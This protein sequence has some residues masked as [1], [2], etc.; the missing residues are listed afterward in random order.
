MEQNVFSSLPLQSE[1]LDIFLKKRNANSRG[2][3]WAENEEA[4]ITSEQVKELFHGK[5]RLPVVSVK[6]VAQSAGWDQ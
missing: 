5:H 4:P 2:E 3:S 1:I 6:I